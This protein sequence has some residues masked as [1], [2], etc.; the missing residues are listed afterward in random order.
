MFLLEAAHVGNIDSTY[1]VSIQATSNESVSVLFA[2]I[3]EHPPFHPLPSQMDACNAALRYLV[4][5]IN[6]LLH[7]HT[8]FRIV[9]YGKDRG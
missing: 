6:Y 9:G 2:P 3:P 7:L 8:G 4:S 5:P 1:F